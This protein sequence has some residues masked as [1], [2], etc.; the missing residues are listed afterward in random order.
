MSER[1]SFVSE[2]IYCDQCTHKIN[3][4][5]KSFFDQK[6]FNFVKLDKFNIFAGKIGGLYQGEELIFFEF[7][8]I[9][10]IEMVI[11]HDV[12]F[13]VLGECGEKIFTA[14]NLFVK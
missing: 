8:V 11:C 3:E 6:F 13:C 7:E 12:R 1:G 10:K 5:L 2:Y 14:R 4:V 9:P